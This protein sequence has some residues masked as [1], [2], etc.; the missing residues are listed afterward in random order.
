MSSGLKYDEDK[1]DFTLVPFDALE[2]AVRAFMYGME[3]YSRDNWKNV[4]DGER[5]YMSA[6]LRHLGKAVDGEELDSES[7]LPHLDHAICSL[8]IAR[9]HA[10]NR[11]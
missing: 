5:R 2:G 9:W 8:L 11:P 4:P 10:F 1:P 6:A 7:A 3:K